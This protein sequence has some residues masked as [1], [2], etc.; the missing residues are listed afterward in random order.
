MVLPV[1]GWARS[2]LPVAAVAFLLVG[3]QVTGHRLPVAGVLARPVAG[4]PVAVVLRVVPVRT[5]GFRL[6]VRP[7]VGCPR[8]ARRVVQ[9]AVV[10]GCRLVM[11]PMLVVDRLAVV[12]P[13]V[14][15]DHLPVAVVLTGTLMCLLRSAMMALVPV[16]ALVMGC[17]LVVPRVRLV[18]GLFPS[19]ML[20]PGRVRLVAVM[21]RVRSMA[22]MCRVRT[23]TA[24]GGPPSLTV[25]V[26]PPSLTAT[27]GRRSLMATGGARMLM[28][29]LQLLML[30]VVR[31]R[32]LTV[33]TRT[34]MVMVRA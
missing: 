18:M 9:L 10:L 31:T 29:R 15:V 24:T 26:G 14:A 22:V 11:A 4:L 3:C 20:V 5:L 1:A 33:R 30:V 25:T 2:S 13:L 6:V 8:V 34:S 28:G 21:C 27:G 23:L 17:R 12:V 16:V 7:R 19:V 32:M